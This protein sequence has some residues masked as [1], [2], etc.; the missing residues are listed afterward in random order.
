M[1]SPPRK[2][3]MPLS[4]LV[5]GLMLLAVVL[6]ACADRAAGAPSSAVR[7]PVTP[8]PA[9]VTIGKGSFHGWDA[10]FLRNRAAE[11]T[12]VPEIGRIMQIALRDGDGDGADGP[13]WSHP[14][15]GPGLGGDE[16][17]WINLGGDK[18]WPA[19]QSRW[20]AIVGKGWPPP[21]TFDASPFEAKIVSG[22]GN[23]GD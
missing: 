9:P 8:P 20:E 19:P 17:G 10:L 7:S 23:A 14:G 1:M 22:A 3:R 6:A 13:F 12:V 15:I 21:R 18:A 5:I 4:L 11:V 16:N 2:R